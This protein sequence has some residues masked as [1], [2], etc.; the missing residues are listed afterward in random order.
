MS[1]LY[2]SP[3]LWWR[4]EL[5]SSLAHGV[6]FRHPLP[7]P[8]FSSTT[9]FF[10][11]ILNRLAFLFLFPLLPVVGGYGI[12]SSF[13]RITKA[14]YVLPFLLSVDE[15]SPFPARVKKL[16]LLPS[17]SVVFSYSDSFWFVDGGGDSFLF[18]SA[19]GNWGV[20]SAAVGGLFSFL[21]VHCKLFFFS[22]RLDLASQCIL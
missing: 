16:F 2:S 21:F 3:I 18:L 6:Q 11:L 5:P 4:K 14:R 1:F 13:F 22:P 12:Y 10:L 7:F 9:F 15:D 19:R 20:C 17:P 8:F